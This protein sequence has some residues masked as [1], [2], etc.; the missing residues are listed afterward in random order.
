MKSPQSEQSRRQDF[1]RIFVLQPIDITGIRKTRVWNNL[2]ADLKAFAIVEHFAPGFPTRRGRAG[3]RRGRM[4][5][6]YHS[7]RL[8]SVAGGFKKFFAE[9]I[10][11]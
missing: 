2:E 8:A 4:K 11:V 3:R 9:K 7:R 5:V 10:E 6:P 1:F